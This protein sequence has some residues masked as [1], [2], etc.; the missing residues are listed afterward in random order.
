MGHMK[1]RAYYPVV[2]V[3]FLLSGFCAILYQIIWLRLAF[4]AFGITTP[5]LSVVVSVFMMGLAIG[6]WAGGRYIGA[7]T[8]RTGLSAIAFY[9]LIELF[10]GVGGLAVP[11]LFKA[12][13]GL[14]LPAGGMDS[15][16]YLF[17]SAVILGA[18]I[19]P[20]CVLMGATIPFMM[21]F[22][23][24]FNRADTTGFSY[25]YFANVIGSMLGAALTACVLIELLGFSA[26]SVLAACCNFAIAIAATALYFRSKKF[27][28]ASAGETG[29][30]NIPAEK[31]A[32][33]GNP[34]AVAAVLFTTGFTS[35][36][37]EVV[38]TR[39][40]TP[41][42][43]TTIY[44]FA[45]I[46]V[47][48]LLATWLGSLSYRRD[49]ARRRVSGIPSLMASLAWFA[50]LPL[51]AGDPRAIFLFKE[52]YAR[53][54]A[55]LA[56]IF[57][58][59]FT[60][61]Y[62]TSAII[63]RFSK[64]DPKAAGRA[65]AVNA[66]GCV[67]G[68][69]AAGYL[70]LPA[71]G[72]RFSLIFLSLPFL[73]F[74]G[75]YHKTLPVKKS[76][77][78]VFAGVLTGALL[79]G[80][81]AYFLSYEDNMLRNPGARIYRDHTATVIGFGSGMQKRLIVN[82]IGMTTMTPITKW[83]AHLPLAACGS[84]PS[85]ALTICLGMGATF[86]SIASWGIE[87]KAV[88][89]APGVGRLFPFYF[90]DAGKILSGPAAR[91]IIDD[92]RRYLRRTSEKFDVITI[93]PPP[94]VEAAGSSLLYSEEFYNI[95]KTRLKE[96]GVMQQ[97]LP[98]G[99][100]VTIRA[101]ANSVKR[102]FPFVRVFHSVEGWGLHFLASTRPLEMPDA[103]GF[104]ARLPVEARNDLVEWN[105]GGDPRRLYQKILSGEIPI[106]IIAAPDVAYAITDDTPINEYF[107][108]R[109]LLYRI[110]RLAFLFTT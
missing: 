13:L 5:I 34:A 16:R 85:S 56:S 33:S 91:I 107:F 48:Y 103:D 31:A 39:A 51:A 25:L 66:V 59:S 68:P 97:W 94:P 7:L 4:A 15:F 79:F 110:R 27:Y 30:E 81:A 62:L 2:F 70:L 40:F 18:S 69:L 28:R 90:S 8:G 49:A 104:I 86:R 78:A 87:V 50:L 46:L 55:V 43:L 19:L 41:V 77:Y 53:S 54:A 88:E 17:L 63:D 12:G 23:R 47:I 72:V 36:A 71:L 96:G 29:A 105:K 93:D 10:I 64:G 98:R 57:P 67:L 89:L 3:F 21:A 37:M 35:M 80:S 26:T 106:G 75:Y 82:G 83:M 84:K 60:L 61:G 109:R 38:W 52:L 14:L 22:I 73:A 100:P 101:V 92:G 11:L 45:G 44:S 58:F 1:R 76:G 108:M 6:S 102:A 9:G 24:Q 42:L 99:D 20:W 74:F 32:S 95:L 65:Y